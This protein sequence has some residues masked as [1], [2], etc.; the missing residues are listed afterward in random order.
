[1]GY[2]QMTKVATS[3][4]I[5]KGKVLTYHYNDWYLS[6]E[7]GSCIYMGYQQMTKVGTSMEIIKGKIAI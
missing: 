5:I 7:K 3:L 6:Q 1:M 2:Q 4:E